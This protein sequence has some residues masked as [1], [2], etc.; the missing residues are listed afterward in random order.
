MGKY[1]KIIDQLPKMAGEE[2]EYQRK[3]DAIK[4]DIVAKQ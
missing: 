4:K 3:I 1:A 2:P